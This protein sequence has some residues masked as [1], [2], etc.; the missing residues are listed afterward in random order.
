MKLT[1]KGC[2]KSEDTGEFLHLENRY[3]KLL[4]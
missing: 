2:L 1:I 4:Y 3:S